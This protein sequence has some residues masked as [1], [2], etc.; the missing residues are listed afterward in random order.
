M[1]TAATSSMTPR[2]RPLFVERS[3]RKQAIAITARYPVRDPV[4]TMMLTANTKST[5]TMT[6]HFRCTTG[7]R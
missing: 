6:R 3:H 5:S 1:P 7:N 2:N 4:N